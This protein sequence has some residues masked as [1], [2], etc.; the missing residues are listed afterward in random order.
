V[1]H[2]AVASGDKGSQTKKDKGDSKGY[3]GCRCGL[4]LS[5][6]ML[7]TLILS[8]SGQDDVQLLR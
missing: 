2:E 1:Y 6:R 8:P 7:D 5:P 3:L 4:L